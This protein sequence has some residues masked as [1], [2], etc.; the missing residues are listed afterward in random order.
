VVDRVYLTGLTPLGEQ[1]SEPEAHSV[2]HGLTEIY[3]AVVQSK[4]PTISKHRRALIIS[5]FDGIGA[6][7]VAL[8]RLQVPVYL[9]VSV[10][11]DKAG[12]R[13][14]RRWWPGSFEC[15]DGEQF[16]GG[17]EANQG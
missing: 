11:L 17:L 6:L 7:R 14:M 5:V 15:T 8:N 4:I 10:E 13:C 2:N 1:K 9:Y 16:D 12:R 3:R